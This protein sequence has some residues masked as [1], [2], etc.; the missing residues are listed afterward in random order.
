M[1]DSK[2][3]ICLNPEH[4]VL[5]RRAA[6][7]L[8]RYAWLLFRLPVEIRPTPPR[9]GIVL[10][11]QVVEPSPV[12][13]AEAYTIGRPRKAGPLTVCHLTGGSPPAVLW[14]A[15]ELIEQWGVHYLFQGDVM[16]DEPG[17]F[18]LPSRDIV[19][20]PRFSDRFFRVVNDLAHSTSMWSLTE[21]HRLLD[22]LVKLRFNGIY[23]ATYPHQPWCHW[24]YRGVNRT[25]AD[26]NYGW[27]FPIHEGS[28]GIEQLGGLGEFTNPDFRGC[29]T[30][31]HR[32]DAGK[33]FMHGLIDAAHHRGLRCDMHHILTA[34]PA[35]IKDHL[36]RWSRGVRLPKSEMAACHAHSLGLA[37][38]DGNA[39]F[40]HLMTP[41]NPAY[42]DMIESWLSALL[43][44][45]PQID[46]LSLGQSEFPPSA[47]GIRQC[48]QA[49]DRRHG[50]SRDFDLD[51]IF[52]RAAKET[53]M[54]EGRAL[55]EAQGAVATLR[56]LDIVINEH[57]VVDRY[58]RPDTPIFCHFMSE[59]LQPVVPRIFDSGRVRFSALVDYLPVT[60]AKRMDTM[61]YVKKS[62]MKVRQIV[63]VEDD[64][65]GFMPQVNTPA[66]HRIMRKMRQHGLMGYSLRH[67]LISKHEQALGYMVDSAWDRTATPRRSYRR[68][69]ERVCGPAAVAPMIAAFERI[70]KTVDL[71]DATIPLGFLTPGLLKR[72]W[73][74]GESGPKRE[75]DKLISI[76][77]G[78][79]VLLDKAAK[80][81]APRGKRYVESWRAYIAFAWRYLEA[82][83]CV[84][85]SRQARAQAEKLAGGGGRAAVIDEYDRCLT[86]SSQHMAAAAT[87][88]EEALRLWRDGIRD[89]SDRGMLA[90]LNAWGLD[91]VRGK[92]SELR[93]DAEYWGLQI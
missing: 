25:K 48:W 58:L 6:E 9:G 47:A 20:K 82:V 87:R 89:P 43:R 35:E 10:R 85:R 63:T 59:F 55:R 44:E 32:I 23:I 62:P 17:P 21:L 83:Q 41:L 2:V 84:R 45:Y 49:L 76:Y 75:L 14:A 86:L 29:H 37:K 18:R 65:V 33:R 90:G 26:L 67:W 92:A 50:L 53:F 79:V 24:S 34:I 42:V 72:A 13:P 30:Y 28:I 22:Q 81:S 51:A 8:A 27:C 64:N 54:S 60:V 12:C 70:E 1:K 80:V 3:S 93:Q 56:L 15:Y 78:V 4:H 16:P 38:D 71:V 31:E 40:G 91:F 11:L 77:S 46:G 39:R 36:G 19:R 74:E 88:M 69:I 7:E 66:L 61:A 5:E 57:R 52:A 73:D 68:Q